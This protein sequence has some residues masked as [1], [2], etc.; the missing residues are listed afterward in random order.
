[1]SPTEDDK[2]G[3]PLGCFFALMIVVANIVFVAI[4][5]IEGCK[6]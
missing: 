1:M 4:L 2:G 3:M 6:P 5:C